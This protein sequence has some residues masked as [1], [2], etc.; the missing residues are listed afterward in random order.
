MW[1]RF[2]SRQE[3]Q[4]KELKKTEDQIMKADKTKNAKTSLENIV[5]V[6]WSIVIV[7]FMHSREK[8]KKSF[9][10]NKKKVIILFGS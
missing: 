4:Q 6:E 5:T 9:M 3:I 2:I 7:I 8:N 10:P 1:A